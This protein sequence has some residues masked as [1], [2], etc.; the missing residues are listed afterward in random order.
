M[1][2]EKRLTQLEKRAD[3]K[4]AEEIETIEVRKS[5]EDGHTEIETI[6][7]VVVKSPTGASPA[8]AT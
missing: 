4:P 1:T 2:L 7:L 6:E 5:Y 3:E 8:T